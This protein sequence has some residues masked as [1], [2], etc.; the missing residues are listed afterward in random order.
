AREAGVGK[1]GAVVL[2]LA[3]AAAAASR[4]LRDPRPQAVESLRIEGI[5][6]T[7]TAAFFR[8]VRA[9][10]ARTVRLFLSTGLSPNVIEPDGGQ[11][12]RAG[13]ALA[14][15]AA[16]GDTTLVATLLAAGAHPDLPNRSG[17]TALFSAVGA[18]NAAVVVRQLLARGADPIHEA[19]DGQLALQAA[20]AEGDT[21]VLGLLLRAVPRARLATLFAR[22][23]GERDINPLTAAAGAGQADAVR[24]LLRAGAPV[25]RPAA[26]P[27]L[28]AAS[29]GLVVDAPNDVEGARRRRDRQAAVVRLLIED[30]RAT[31][32]PPCDGHSVLEWPVRANDTTLVAYLLAHGADPNRAWSE[33]SPPVRAVLGWCE[34][35]LTA[36]DLSGM[37][38]LLTH[39]ARADWR[40]DSSAPTPLMSAAYRNAPACVD[41]LLAAGA[42]VN[43]R[44]GVGRTPLLWAANPWNARVLAQLLARGADPRAVDRDGATALM[45]LAYPRDD[46]DAEE[47]G[48]APLDALAVLLR[49]GVDPAARRAD[50]ATALD[51]ARRNGY[52]GIAVRLGGAGTSGRPGPWR[53]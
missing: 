19:D 38:Y 15:A 36:D 8:A 34:P 27:P 1:V 12:L 10:D 45:R 47:R 43:A 9:G 40:P 42:D 51:L 14:L 48:G 35:A 31:A 22:D 6:A 49:A 13:P 30:A 29:N 52:R 23:S 16:R 44:D 25:D 24:M 41:L 28:C 37:R 18:P 11:G 7:D 3:A 39:G 2:A 5:A 21:L 32:D 26:R 33:E 4:A 20:A 50:G 53:R 46:A 17:Y